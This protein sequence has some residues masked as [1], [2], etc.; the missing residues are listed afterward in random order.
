MKKRLKIFALGGNELSPA[1]LKETSAGKVTVQSIEEQWRRTSFTCNLLANIIKENP[2]DYYILTHGN[3]PQVGEL[4]MNGNS[5]PIELDVCDA[6][7]QGSM[8]YMLSQLT[9]SLSILGINKIAAETITKVVVDEYDI[10]FHSPSK[11]IGPSFSKET[12]L[13]KQSNEN[14]PFRFYKKD[15]N[16]NELWRWVV[17]SPDP[18]EIVEIELIE[19]NLRAGIIPI[20]VG[21]G[22]IPVKIVK[23]IILNGEEI[24]NCKF[25]ID[26]RRKFKS[27]NPPVRIYSGVEAVIDK[28]L[29]S[30]LLG[31][32]LIQ[33]AAQ[34][35]D[36]LEAEL[37]IFTDI[38]GVK[39]NY[40]QQDQIDLRYLTLAEIKNF[41]GEKIFPE[42]SMGP[43]I[44][45]AINFLEGG[46]K[47]VFITRSDFYK[48]TL[49]G[50]RGTLIENK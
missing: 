16:G 19:A 23:P 39:L 13:K 31:T 4:I 26:Y 49:K 47:R 27:G 10:A 3:G 28:D 34:S 37:T 45:A 14:H 38:D 15:E 21:G 30:S 43:K 48:E 33:R 11:F 36:E 40:Q 7:T 17:A 50:R 8:G 12:A 35:G 32:T 22:G 24:Y 20:A 1:G 41:Y 46:G 2:D 9:N 18:V 44:K 42:G 29:A 25:G 5:A 6:D